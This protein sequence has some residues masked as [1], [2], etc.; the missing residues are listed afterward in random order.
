[1]DIFKEGDQ[2]DEFFVLDLAGP[3]FEDN[4]VLRL[5]FCVRGDGVD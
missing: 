4:G 3:F 5:L 2:R 1:M